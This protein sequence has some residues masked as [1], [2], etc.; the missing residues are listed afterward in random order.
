MIRCRRASLFPA[1]AAAVVL[2]GFAPEAPTSA[3]PRARVEELLGAVERIIE[4][5]DFE[6]I[7]ADLK[8]AMRLSESLPD[9]ALIARCLDLMGRAAHDRGD[10][11][12]GAERQQRAIEIARSI[13][14]RRLEAEI[15]AS[16]GLSLWQHADYQHAIENQERALDIQRQIGDTT[17]EA[18]TLRNIALVHFKQ[19]AYEKALDFHLRALAM[20]EGAGDLYAQS[21]SLED[22][23]SLYLDR[24]DYAKSLDFFEHSRALRERMGDLRGECAL[25]ERI[26]VCYLFQGA[27]EEARVAYRRALE[28]AE[29]SDDESGRAR[30]LH[31]LGMVYTRQGESILALECYKTALSI[32]QRM[33]DRRAQAWNLAGIASAYEEIG[34]F[35]QALAYRKRAHKIWEDIQDRRAL[36]SDLDTTGELCYRMG[37]YRQAMQY[38]QRAADL[39]HEIHLPYVSLSFANIGLVFAKLGDAKQAL[40]FGGRAVEEAAR[41]GNRDMKAT[42][43]YRLGA[44]QRD[45]GQKEE[46]LKSFRASLEMIEEMRADVAPADEAKVG[47]LEAR[48]Q[49]YADTIALL[50]ELGR[51]EEALE[52]AER[53]RARAFVDLLSARELQLAGSANATA[54]SLAAGRLVDGEAKAIES[55]TVD[56]DEIVARGTEGVA[57][58]SAKTPVEG[59]D[60][61]SLVA[62]PPAGLAELRRDVVSHNTT[63][64]EYFEMGDGLAI[65]VVD[66]RGGIRGAVSPIRATDLQRIIGEMRSAMRVSVPSRDLETGAPPVATE[67]DARP[68]L[69]RLYRV[70]IEPVER[71]LPEDAADLV[72]FVPHGPLFLVSFAALL[73]RHDRYLVERHTISYSPAISVLHYTAE[74]RSRVVHRD[75]PRLLLVG[76]PEMPRLPWSGKQMAPLPGAEAEAVS[77]G[78]LFPQPQA[79]V[80]SGTR[81]DERSIKDLAPEQTVIHLATHGVVRDDLPLESFLAL[82]PTAGDDGRLTAREIFG[83]DLHADLVVLSACNTGLGRVNGDGVIGL[84]RAFIYAGAPSVMVTLWRVADIVA[85]SEM[86]RFYAVLTTNGGRKA[87]ALR[88][89]QLDTIR[90]LRAKEMKA[91]SGRPLPEH[92]IFWAP[93]IIVGEAI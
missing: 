75:A 73:D 64:V 49:V 66:P 19:G 3:D 29:A 87:A 31:G 51:V 81:A 63:L 72:T 54:P 35:A 41:T 14:D 67:L 74:E 37:D 60:V 82:A 84:S 32:R 71:W 39:G 2:A 18:S 15:L 40:A 50:M 17:G 48:E 91:P 58:P 79:T 57:S 76:N 46:A 80:L 12:A 77:I 23:G 20:R 10:A 5:R 56:D 38:F 89:A 69:R 26:G 86:E 33:G 44:I 93:F 34:N 43:S 24:H 70:L 53:A 30:T 90:R 65:W 45:L 59:L 27:S 9:Q 4:D 11:A 8:E 28:L 52:L 13:G 25:Y 21:V 85:R 55:P 88:Q 92:A 36:A 68:V 22:I 78:R 7:D 42:A 62:M 6:R 16:I 47:F 1:I 83:L 61:P